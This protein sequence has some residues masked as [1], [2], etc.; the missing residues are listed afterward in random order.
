MGHV[1][2]REK[3]HQ[4]LAL[5]RLGWSLRQIEDATG[6]RRETASR[7]LKAAGVAVRRPGRWG[8]PDP[9]AAIEV[10]TDSGC[11]PALAR[12]GRSPSASACEPYRE[13][14]E[15]G[16]AHGRDAMSMWQ[17]LVDDHGFAHGYQSVR[18]FVVTL[19]GEQPLEAHPTIETAPGAEGQVD[20]GEG[21]M[22]LHAGTG[23]YR[24]MRLFVFTLGCSRK[25]V[26]LLTFRSSTQIW[27]ELHEQAFRRLGGTSRVVVLDN[28]KEGVL[29]PDVYDPALNPVYR[30]MLAHYG[31]TALPCRVRDP[32]RKGKVESGVQHAQRKLRGLRFAHPDDAQAYLDRWETNWADTRIHGTTKRQV[33]AMFAEEQ[34]HLQ[35]LPTEPFRYYQFGRRTEHLDG[36]VEVAGAYYHLPPGHIGRRLAVQWDALHVRILEPVTGALLREHLRQQKVHHRMR[37]EDRPTKTPVSTVRLL[38]R[39][40]TAGASIGVVCQTI[41]RCLCSSSTTSACASCRRTPPRTSL[42]SSCAVMNEPVRSLRPTAQSRTGVSSWATRRQSPPCSTASS[43]TAISSSAARGVGDPERRRP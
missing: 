13:L 11:P 2:D 25:S 15:A 20:Y 42:R 24:R 36:A 33:A 40:A 39:A 26:R 6:V 8:H 21:P 12:P 41:H 18:R 43:T 29:T 31:V 16:V 17:D 23:N 35:K 27:A 14:V 4:I 7:Y 28:L 10:I 34:P 30:D 9:K 38:A 1:L 5:G 3:Q 19:R 22:V 32:N 37:D